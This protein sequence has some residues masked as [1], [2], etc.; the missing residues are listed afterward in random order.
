M[1]KSI[2][3]HLSAPSFRIYFALQQVILLEKARFTQGQIFARYS[4]PTELRLFGSFSGFTSLV[5]SLIRQGLNSYPVASANRLVFV[6]ADYSA[7]ELTVRITDGGS[8]LRYQTKS[9]LRES[10]QYL[11][12]QIKSLNQLEKTMKY[13]FRG[14]ITIHNFTTRGTQV[15]LKF[16]V[17]SDSQTRDKS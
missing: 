1:I 14:E 16:P 6:T 9:Y 4:I 8:G 3:N 15:T 2:L 12:D 17:P 7:N 13:Q 11:P 5:S 10:S